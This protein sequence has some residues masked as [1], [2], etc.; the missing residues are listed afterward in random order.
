MK[1]LTQRLVFIIMV[2]TLVAEFSA[3]CKILKCF[4]LKLL[5]LLLDEIYACPYMY[6][7]I[8]IYIKL[9]FSYAILFLFYIGIYKIKIKLCNIFLMQFYF[10]LYNTF[11]E[12][13]FSKFIFKLIY[14]WINFELIYYTLNVWNKYIEV[15]DIYIILII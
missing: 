15:S 14:F 5:N 8:Y 3:N 11:K 12:I 7:C 6:I 13:N 10:Y 2:E 1:W 9:R 4:A